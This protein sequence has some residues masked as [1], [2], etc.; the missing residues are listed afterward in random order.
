MET[1]GL[2]YTVNGNFTVTLHK[3]AT[4]YI[5]QPNTHVLITKDFQSQLGNLTVDV[6][7]AVT[8]EQSMAGSWVEFEGEP[9]HKFNQNC[10]EFLFRL[11]RDAVLH[12]YVTPDTQALQK[13]VQSGGNVG[14]VIG[15]DR[16]VM[17]HVGGDFTLSISLA[18]SLSDSS[19]LTSTITCTADSADDCEMTIV[20]TQNLAQNAVVEAYGEE[21]KILLKTNVPVT[22]N[23]GTVIQV[24]CRDY[25]DRRVL[26]LVD[27]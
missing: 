4:Y 22:V 20:F 17:L 9:V 7:I 25:E 21:G 19:L 24:S 26:V 8:N 27:L 14:F 15:S 10:T 11:R 2:R 18:A 1:P 3:S 5:S 16:N 6:R 13:T 23:P 12:Q